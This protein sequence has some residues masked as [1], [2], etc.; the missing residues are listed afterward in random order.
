ICLKIQTQ[1]PAILRSAQAAGPQLVIRR[2]AQ[3]VER[4]FL[5]RIS[6]ALKNLPAILRSVQE[7]EQ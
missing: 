2:S 7:V 4:V 6:S 5:N 3:V 1:L